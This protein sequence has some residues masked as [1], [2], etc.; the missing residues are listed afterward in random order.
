MMAWPWHDRILY[1]QKKCYLY[2]GTFASQDILTEGGLSEK[3]TCRKRLIFFNVAMTKSWHDINTK[4][5]M[6][7]RQRFSSSDFFSPRHIGKSTITIKRKRF[8]NSTRTTLSKFSFSGKSCNELVVPWMCR[9]LTWI[10]FF[11]KN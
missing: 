6:R 5:H 11:Y 9:V 1:K 7:W 8:Y 3:L 4:A 10:Y 2:F